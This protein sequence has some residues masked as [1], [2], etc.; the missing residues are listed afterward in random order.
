MTHNLAKV[1]VGKAAAALVQTGMTVGLGSG[2]TAFYFIEELIL[3]CKQG[4]LIQ[5]VATS[6]ASRLQ[7]FAGSIPLIDETKVTSIDL[8]VDGADEIDPKGR[9]IKGGGGALLREKIVA[10]HSKK[11]VIIADESKKVDY[12]GRFPLAVEIIPFC[13]HATIEK[14]VQMGYQ[15]KI[16][17]TRQTPFITDNGNYIF[18][19]QL[20]YPCKHPEE[21]HQ[22]IRTLVGVVETGFFL[23]PVNLF[24]IGRSDG[25]VET[26]TN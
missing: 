12:L 5:A 3:R 8:T 16:R 23:M 18:D 26:I 4:L 13:A 2:S 15:G 24:L 14:L 6:E 19:I 11:Y 21:D 9:L 1:A 7:A 22:R 17:A 20:P 10:T 25:T